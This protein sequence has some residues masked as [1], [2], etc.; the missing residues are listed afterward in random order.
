MTKPHPKSDAAV[1]GTEGSAADGG[2]ASVRQ[3]AVTRERLGKEALV[4]FVLSPEGAVTPDV[5]EKLPGRGV[6]VRADR[7]VLQEAVK[8]K[9][10]ARAFKSSVI[11]PE[12]LAETV[13][14]LLVRRF[15]GLL[16]MAKK[17]GEVVLGFDQVREALQKRA[18]GLLLE[19]ADG[20]EDGRS[21]LYFLAKALYSDVE[22]AGALTSAELGM[23]FGRDRVVHGLVRKGPFSKALKAAYARLAG[24]RDRPELDWFSDQDR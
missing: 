9:A 24:F 11:V 14:A 15:A 8:K 22:V 21:K 16:G 5:A 6:W 10:F 20:A 1:T 23:A 7:A 2:E 13:E 4:R 19:A 12:A 3:C 18:P 17:G